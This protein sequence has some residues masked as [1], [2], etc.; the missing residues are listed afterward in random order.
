L[1]QKILID[2]DYQDK[3]LVKFLK[4]AGHNIITVN[5]VGLSGSD[6]AIVLDYARRQGYLV[7]TRNCKD[8]EELHQANANHPGILGVY[9]DNDPLKNMSFQN[10][11][12][13][14]ANLEAAGVP[15]TNQFISLNQWNY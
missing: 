1:S 8:F 6:D 11:V 4:N 5:D 14:I 12:R 15:L 3:R 10:V 13:A 9:Q 2:E 7:L